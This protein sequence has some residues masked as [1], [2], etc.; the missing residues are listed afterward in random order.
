MKSW[1]I[2]QQFACW[3]CIICKVQRESSS[4]VQNSSWWWW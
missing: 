3:F 2:C 1:T 4:C